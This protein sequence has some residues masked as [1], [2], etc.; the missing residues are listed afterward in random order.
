MSELSDSALNEAV[1]RKPCP[2]CGG[3]GLM[4]FTYGNMGTDPAVFVRCETCGARTRG[5]YPEEKEKAIAFWNRREV[6]K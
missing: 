1:A 5:A 6:E 4:G 3:K 2:F